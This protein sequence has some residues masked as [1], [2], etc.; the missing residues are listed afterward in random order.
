MMQNYQKNNQQSAQ[1]NQMN[2]GSLPFQFN[3]NAVPFDFNPYQTRY[4]QYPATQISADNPFLHMNKSPAAQLNVQSSQF[5][6]IEGAAV[7][8]PVSN[9]NRDKL[10]LSQQPYFE[11]SQQSQ[12]FDFY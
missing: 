9:N 4:P 5:Q 7:F 1:F 2:A 6:P 3:N 8:N 10:P 11:A 12:G